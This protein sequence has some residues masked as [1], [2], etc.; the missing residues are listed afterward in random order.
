MCGISNALDD[1]SVSPSV[2]METNEEESESNGC[3]EHGDANEV[4]PFSK[5]SDSDFD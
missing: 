2:E 5:D 4:D 1:L 3:E